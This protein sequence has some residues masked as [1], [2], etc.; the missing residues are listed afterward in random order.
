VPSNPIEIRVR[1]DD[2]QCKAASARAT[3]AG[4]DSVE[5]WV[6]VLVETELRRADLEAEISQAIDQGDFQQLAAELR[7]KLRVAPKPKPG[8]DRS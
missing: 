4:F 6:Q 8:G 1:L 7:D 5:D 3:Q 2:T